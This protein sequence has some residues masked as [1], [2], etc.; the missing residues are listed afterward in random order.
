M[1]DIPFFGGKL[2]QRVGDRVGERILTHPCTLRESQFLRPRSE[3]PTLDLVAPTTKSAKRPRDLVQPRRE[4]RTILQRWKV[5][6]SPHES[7][8]RE[9][10]GVRAIAEKQP[11][12]EPVDSRFESLDKR[13]KSL[14]LPFEYSKD[15]R[16]A[17]RR[18]T[19]FF[20]SSLVKSC[21]LYRC[22][23]V[24]EFAE[25]LSN[26]LYLNAAPAPGKDPRPVVFAGSPCYLAARIFGRTPAPSR[27]HK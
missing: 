7:L 23:E 20:S 17:V 3:S 24:T 26:R 5:A 22:G 13:A 21:H 12:A 27:F 2:A 15:K 11:A 8:L 4:A 14:S 10:F 19:L 18:S 9:I 6:K 16:R 25:N 1:K